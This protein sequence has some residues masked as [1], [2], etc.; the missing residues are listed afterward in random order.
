MAKVEDQTDEQLLDGDRTEGEWERA[1]V[2]EQWWSIQALPFPAPPIKGTGLLIPISS[3]EDL[4]KEHQ[5]FGVP[6]DNFWMR[7]VLSPSWESAYFFKWC[8]RPPG[9]V[10]TIFGDYRLTRVGCLGRGDQPSPNRTEIVAS[11]IRAFAAAE[12]DVREARS[13]E[14]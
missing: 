10:L 5:D 11:V 12:F 4:I 9:I 13:N 14:N 8:G 7:S 6:L 3:V 2:D 1:P